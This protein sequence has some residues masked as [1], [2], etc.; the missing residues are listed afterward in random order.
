MANEW[1]TY[2]I[3]FPDTPNRK[4][5]EGRLLETIYHVAHVPGARRILEDGRL[6][7]RIVYDESKLRNSRIAVTWLSANSWA[8]GSI[9]GNVEFS[10]SWK[11]IAA[12]KN[13]YWVEDMRSYHPWAY[14]TSLTDREINSKFV[15]TYDPETDKGPLRKKD[16]VWYWNG[17]YTSEFM[18]ERD[19]SLEECTTFN[20]VS[21]HPQYCNLNG[22]GCEHLGYAPHRIAGRVMATIL[23]NDLHAIDHVLLFAVET[24][25]PEVLNKLP[26]F[27][28]RLEWFIDN[29]PD[30]TE[31]LA[32]MRTEGEGERRLLSI[33]TADQLRA[34]LRYM[35]DENEFLSPYG[36]RAVSRFHRENPYKL[37]VNGAEHRVDYEPGE[38]STGLFGGNSNWRGPIWFPVNFLLVESLQ[39]FHHYLGDEFKVEFPTGS[40]RMLTL[41]DI[42][43][44]L[45]RRLTATFLRDENG[46]RPVFGNLEKFQADPH[47]RDLVLFHEYFHGDTGAG[48]G[49]SHQTGWTGVVTKLMQQSGESEQKKQSSAARVAAD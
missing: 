43:A 49:A 30:L 9:Y 32:C 42:A 31:N 6:K 4:F 40:G 7:A 12:N 41:W 38:S 25:E 47:W 15:Q 37:N 18:L 16:G 24:L 5:T 39:K 22:S 45:S 48:V 36:I 46:R 20:F 11:K 19:V 8:W 13:F 1:S 14:R 28:R 2:R 23:G 29:R 44:E 26:D 21:H 17:E 10:F 35:L 34:I 27:K 33:A 3:S